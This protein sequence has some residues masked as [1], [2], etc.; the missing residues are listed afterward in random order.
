[1]QGFQVGEELLG[2][3]HALVQIVK[4]VENEL[5][6]AVKFVERV[7]GCADVLLV[8]LIETADKIKVVGHRE[9]RLG[10]KEFADGEKGGTPDGLVGQRDEVLIEKQ[11]GTLV[12]EDNGYLRQV[13]AIFLVN[14]S[15]YEA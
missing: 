4:I 11:T 6:P 10:A 13:V 7:G 14:I 12:G 1:M 15:G 9:R 3:D 5:S 2:I 8:N